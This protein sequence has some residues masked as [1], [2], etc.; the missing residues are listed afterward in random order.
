MSVHVERMR[1]LGSTNGRYRP[2]T[3]SGKAAAPPTGS[4]QPWVFAIVC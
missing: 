1:A 2:L 3:A 4:V